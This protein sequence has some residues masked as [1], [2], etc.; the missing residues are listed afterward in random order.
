MPVDRANLALIITDE[1]GRMALAK[2]GVPKRGPQAGLAGGSGDRADE[3]RCAQ[4]D[5]VGRVPRGDAAGRREE[6]THAGHTVLIE[7]G[8]GQGSGIADVAYADSGATIVTDA[9]EIWA[10]A[11][12][13]V[14]VKE[15]QPAEWLWLRPDQVV[16]TYFHFAADE[17]LTRAII[18]SD[19]TAIAYETLRDARGGLPLLT[20][21]SEVAGRM[22]IQE[23]AKFLERPQEGRGILLSGVPGVAPA[24]IAILGGGS[25]RVQR[26]QGRRR[27]WAPTCGSSTSTSIACVISTISCRPT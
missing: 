7:A 10:E 26:R 5:Q 27:S 1:S 11:E 3:G 6:L 20:P 8:A 16:F 4:R 15:P 25:R 17:A 23:G 22:S 14:K 12:L 13:I 18:D 24:E 9:A 2:N 21:M 19:I